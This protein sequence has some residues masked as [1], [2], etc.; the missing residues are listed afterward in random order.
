MKRIQ[1]FEFE[2]L[3][4]FPKN[5]RNYGTDFLQFGANAFDIYKPVL[6]LLKQAIGLTG[7]HTVID[8]ASGGG[9]GWIALAKHLVKEYPDVR[10]FLS[11]Y[12]PNL[13]AFKRTKSVFPANIDYIEKPVDAM[14]V[15]ADL[16]GF[17]TQFLSF[18][19]FK[20]HQA[21]DILQN[22]ID[23][24]QPVGIFEA[25]QRNVKSL[26][27]MLLSPVS[28]LLMTPFIQPFRWDRILFTYL[29]PLIPLLVLWDGIVSVLRTYTIPEARE[30]VSGLREKDKFNWQ[31]GIAKGKPNNI[32]YLIGLPKA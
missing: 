18:H 15:P 25:Q 27:P 21:K 19:H 3:S 16:K 30:M 31:I 6:P 22:A 1:A 13:E 14:D 5:L 7:N 10:I 23:R 24:N 20:P 28:V 8:I 26:I 32:F 29:I 4:W 2:D 9:G 11:D 12:F 17:R